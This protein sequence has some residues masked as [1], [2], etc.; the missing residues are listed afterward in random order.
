MLPRLGEKEQ[1]NWSIELLMLVPHA[2]CM[3]MSK[4]VMNCKKQES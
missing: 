1:N 3:Y 2:P 4:L